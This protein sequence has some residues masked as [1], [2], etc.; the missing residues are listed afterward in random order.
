[1]SGVGDKAFTSSVGIEVLG[2][3]VDIK[4]MGPA[5]P[6]LSGD[7]TYSTAVAKAMIAALR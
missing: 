1:V 7:Y 3:G 6:V 4:V 2:G 5:G